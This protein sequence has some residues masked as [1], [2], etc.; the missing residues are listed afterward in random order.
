MDA[1]PALDR[2]AAKK[3]DVVGAVGVEEDAPGHDIHAAEHGGLVID[4]LRR[5]S[6]GPPGGARR[7]FDTHAR[8]EADRAGLM[9]AGEETDQAASGR[10]DLI[11][12]LLEVTRGVGL[13]R[14]GFEV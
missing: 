7:E 10:G 6:T 11:D 12:G 5:I 3:T 1:P 14:A 8:F 2:A 9:R 13:G 4:E